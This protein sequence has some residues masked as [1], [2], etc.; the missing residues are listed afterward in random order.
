MSG[1]HPDVVIVGG[2]V[3]GLS[4]AY[5]LAREGIRCTLL[6]RRALGREASWAGAGLIAASTDRRSP[7]PLEA[8]RSWSARLYPEWSLALREETGIDNGYRVTGGVDVAWTAEEDQALRALAGRWRSDGIAFERLAPGD[9]DRVE[10]RLN[11]LLRV[12]YFLPDRAQ[13]RNPRHLQARVAAVEARGSRLLTDQAVTGFEVRGSRVTAVN[14][15]DDSIT[16]G[17]VVLA[18]G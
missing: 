17:A 6:E 2:G 5:V 11:P 1:S 10:P 3:I 14:T 9:F 4:V 8:L 7:H 12:A 16:C 15:Q 18:A 13:I